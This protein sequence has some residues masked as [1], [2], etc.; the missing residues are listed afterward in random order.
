MTDNIVTIHQMTKADIESVYR[1]ECESFIT[2]WSKKSLHD[3]LTNKLAHYGVL[4]VN[5]EPIAYAGMWVMFDEAHITNVAVTKSH[6]GKGFGR[7]IM[8]YMVQ[9]A[10]EKGAAKMTLE[11]RQ[12][13]LTAQSLYRSMG[14]NLCGLRKGYYRDTG[15]DALIMWADI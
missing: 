11:V 15:E 4:C 1:I 8:E 14:F 6:R 13:N 10:K 9:K 7:K 2:P 5:G 12:T 3:E